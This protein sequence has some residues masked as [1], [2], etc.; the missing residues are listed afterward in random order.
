MIDRS[1]MAFPCG[2]QTV[3]LALVRNHSGHIDRLRQLHRPL[4]GRA[5][6]IVR[7]PM[8]S[9]RSATPEFRDRPF[10]VPDHSV[11]KGV[12]AFA[13]SAAARRRYRAS[14]ELSE[15]FAARSTQMR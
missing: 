11:T 2:R 14:R 1:A 9:H 10:H 13:S 15:L 5:Q 6:A 3:S 7:Y 4:L 8:N 12:V